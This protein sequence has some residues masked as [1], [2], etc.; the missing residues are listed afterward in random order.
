[1]NFYPKKQAMIIG[2]MLMHLHLLNGQDVGA[3]MLKN[4]DGIPSTCPAIIKSRVS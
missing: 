4:L 1:M 3:A 2:E